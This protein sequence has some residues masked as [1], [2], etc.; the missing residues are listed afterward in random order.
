MFHYSKALQDAKPTWD[1]TK[2]EKW[3]TDTESLL[4]LVRL[5]NG[6]HVK[7]AGWALHGQVGMRI[8]W[9]DRDRAFSERGM[10]APSGRTER[11]P[12]LTCYFIRFSTRLVA[13]GAPILASLFAIKSA[14]GTFSTCAIFSKMTTFGLNPAFHQANEGSV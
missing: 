3:L 12:T 11:G 10:L 8:L 13:P 6:E 1:E 5:I 14:A 4:V 2:L 7:R 9:G